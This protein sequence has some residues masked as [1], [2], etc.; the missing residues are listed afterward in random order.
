MLNQA[1]NYVSGKIGGV[2]K[3]T[4]RSYEINRKTILRL[5]DS[6]QFFYGKIDPA[7]NLRGFLYPQKI[8]EIRKN[9]W[10]QSL[11]VK[12]TDN[13]TN[14]IQVFEQTF[15][16]RSANPTLSAQIVESYIKAGVLNED[17]AI[18]LSWAYPLPAQM[19]AFND[20]L[21][22][23]EKEVTQALVDYYNP[24]SDI[25]NVRR[26]LMENAVSRLYYNHNYYQ[27]TNYREFVS[28]F[29]RFYYSK[30]KPWQPRNDKELL[31]KVE[32]IKRMLQDFRDLRKT[33][34]VEE[35]FKDLYN[36]FGVDTRIPPVG[37][38]YKINIKTTTAGLGPFA[39]TSGSIEIE[40]I[41]NYSTYPKAE[42]WKDGN[43]KTFDIR[44]VQ[45]SVSFL[46]IDKWRPKISARF[47]AEAETQETPILYH[48]DD[49]SDAA[50]DM[51]E[52]TAYEFSAGKNTGGNRTEISGGYTKRLLTLSGPGK[53]KLEFE[54]LEDTPFI[55]DSVTVQPKEDDHDSKIF[56]FSLPN[57]T[58]YKGYIGEKAITKSTAGDPLADKFTAVY[59]LTSFTF[60]KHDE[61]PLQLDAINA[62]GKMCAE[63]LAALTDENT[64][65]D[66]TGHADA[67]GEAKYN[68]D[69]SIARAEN[70]KQAIKDRLG[71]K[72]RATIN[73]VKGM[74]EDEAN[75][76]GQW[77]EKNAWRRRVF[78]IINGKAVLMLGE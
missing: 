25:P 46:A 76:L 23:S 26:N 57:V 24:T 13:S 60:F 62:V 48:P 50:V 41:T 42:K 75:K 3:K 16:K 28:Y 52:W 66:I 15:N 33:E 31:R 70:V 72:L 7:G 5:K 1:G 14:P 71:I 11:N 45:A 6:V 56:D 18:T 78:V 53:A 49:F 67:S 43:Q 30:S 54:Q 10:D 59:Q 38:K 2:F 20:F 12:I 4:L 69:L 58:F 35:R 47:Q 55:P 9:S 74:G 44:L 36:F 77:K 73:P 68:K 22:K 21:S 34:F 40:N 27:L 17:L 65:V 61:A 29:T 51:Q 64:I 63:E 8:V 19:K 32:W 39:V 37:Y